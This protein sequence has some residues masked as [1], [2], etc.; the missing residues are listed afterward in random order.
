MVKR[1]KIFIYFSKECLQMEEFPILFEKKEIK[2]KRKIERRISYFSK[3]PFYSCFI[4]RPSHTCIL[5]IDKELCIIEEKKYFTI[6]FWIL[7]YI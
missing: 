3:S 1:S 4:Q 6:F 2:Y 5:H 7:Q